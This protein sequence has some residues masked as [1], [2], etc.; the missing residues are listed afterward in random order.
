MGLAQR[1]LRLGK[2]RCDSWGCWVEIERKQWADE[3]AGTRCTVIT[4]IPAAQFHTLMNIVKGTPPRPLCS[5]SGLGGSQRFLCEP[6]ASSV[7]LSQKS[8]TYSRV[9]L[10]RESSK[11]RNFSRQPASQGATVLQQ[12]GS[13]STQSP[14]ST[15]CPAR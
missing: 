9:S 6:S 7:L 12:P 5:S 8:S 14:P 4:A 1:L 3:E 15:H 10:Q 13:T 2:A 11:Y